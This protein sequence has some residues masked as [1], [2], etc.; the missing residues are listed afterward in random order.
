M[1]WV[2]VIHMH[3]LVA[4]SLHAGRALCLGRWSSTLLWVCGPPTVCA[5]WQAHGMGVH[6]GARFLGSG[7]RCRRRQKALVPASGCLGNG[8]CCR[9]ASVTV[10]TEP[11]PLRAGWGTPRIESGVEA[12]FLWKG[13][14]PLPQRQKQLGE[15]V[16]AGSACFCLQ[17]LLL[18]PACRSGKAALLWPVASS[19]WRGMEF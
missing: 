12:G 13:S 10:S 7:W 11:L 18:S 4:A 2:R 14:V 5:E 1:T 9:T 15:E 16:L 3:T 6:W 19:W 8:R 17:L